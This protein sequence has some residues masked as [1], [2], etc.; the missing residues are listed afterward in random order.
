MPIYRR[1][2]QNSD[3]TNETEILQN[4]YHKFQA[5]RGTDNISLEES[6]LI[7][8]IRKIFF[9]LAE[10]RGFEEVFIPSFED[11]EL[12][13]RSVGE[14]T[15][16]VEKEMFLLEDRKEGQEKK[17]ALR[18]EATA[19]ICRK[20]IESG[21]ISLPQP[22]KVFFFGEVFR[23][24]RPQAGRFRQFYQLDL[25][26]IGSKSPVSDVEIIKFSWDFL[27]KLGLKNLRLEINSIGCL[28]CRPKYMKNLKTHFESYEKSLS[29]ES[30]NRMKK[31]MLRV[32]DSK[33]EK[34]IR[35]ANLAPRMIDFLCPECKD[36]FDSVKNSLK[37]LNINFELNHKLVRGLDYYTKT[38]FEIM[39]YDDFEGP[40]SS[41]I[42]GGRYDNLIE[43]LGGRET[44]AVGAGMGVERIMQELKLQ[45]IEP[46]LEKKRVYIAFIGKEA[47]S[48]S[49][50][51]S[52][53]L[54]SAGF[55]VLKPSA[56]LGISAQ[57]KEANKLGVSWVIML[58]EHEIETN[59]LILKE[60][61][62]GI[63]SVI[64]REKIIEDLASKFQVED[65]E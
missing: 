38:T 10:E 20:Y 63:Q 31:N 27:E 13:K 32:L 50:K 45:K 14:G 40:R 28:K 37:A 5:P 35:V 19:G 44:P 46:K 56:Q 15:D 3:F 4:N 29:E 60:L 24:E 49:I 36:H 25:E 57:F 17:F 64:L 11:V 21:W 39:P 26:T 23:A 22:V 55:K 34:D 58:G 7:R 52:A 62:T 42:G 33:D 41:L 18:P 8:F 9:K 51:L 53:T 48:E 65:D 2:K 1:V 6:K 43:N 16:I 54:Q 61:K 59:T 12:F 47:E 30:K